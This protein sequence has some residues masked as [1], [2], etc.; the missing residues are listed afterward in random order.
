MKR[1]IPKKHWR[2]LLIG[3]LVLTA[4]G[5]AVVASRHARPHT[6]PAVSNTMVEQVRRQPAL[7][8]ATERD[9]SVLLQA[10]KANQVAGLALAGGGQG[11]MAIVYDRSSG[12]ALYAP[13]LA[14]DW[15]ALARAPHT[16]GA[17][18]ED[19]SAGDD[20]DTSNDVVDGDPV[21]GDPDAVHRS[22]SA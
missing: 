9:V 4:A 6:Q 3:V 5:A 18:A 1:S 8:T 11:Q 17:V 2:R 21:A 20:G 15:T 10:M 22:L 7:W 14:S 16:R 13:P 19:D 12:R